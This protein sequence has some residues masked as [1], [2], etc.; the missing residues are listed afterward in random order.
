MVLMAGREGIFSTRIRASSLSD[1]PTGTDASNCGC[2]PAGEEYG[3]W[4]SAPIATVAGSP[5]CGC[6]HPVPANESLRIISGRLGTK[7]VT[8][9]REAASMIPLALDNAE[10]LRILD[11]RLSNMNTRITAASSVRATMVL[12]TALA[13][14]PTCG[15][16]GCGFVVVVLN[17]MSFT[18][19]LRMVSEAWKKGTLNTDFWNNGANIAPCAGL[20]RI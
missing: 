5:D 19:I 14:T 9:T 15:F 7:G 11:L 18:G 20:A 6:C 3:P 16:F 12:M 4:P 10:D 2:R 1:R 17:W 8:S 13:T